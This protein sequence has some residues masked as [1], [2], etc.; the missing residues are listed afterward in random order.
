MVVVVMVVVVAVV[1]VL[2]CSAWRCR[3]GL[4][5]RHWI[6]F[7]VLFVLAVLGHEQRSRSGMAAR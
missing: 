6:G 3:V 2:P 1:H 4:P 7:D 5:V